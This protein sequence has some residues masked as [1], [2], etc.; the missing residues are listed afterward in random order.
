[1]ALLFGVCF[2]LHFLKLS[3]GKEVSVIASNVFQFQIVSSA[4]VNLKRAKS[5]DLDDI[6]YLLVCSGMQQ[7]ALPN[8]NWND[9]FT[10]ERSTGSP[11]A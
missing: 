10:L 8:L 7:I 5:P 3:A 1:M 9:S 4:E 11:S 2:F 6:Q